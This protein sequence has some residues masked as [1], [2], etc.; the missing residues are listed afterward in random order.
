MRYRALTDSGDSTF[1]SGLTAFLVNTPDAVAQAVRTRLLLLKGEWFL[2][3]Q[4]GTPYATQVLGTGT[5]ATRDVVIQNRII[6]TQGVLSIT[7]YS[8]SVNAD[9][10][11]FSINATIETVYGSTTISQV[12]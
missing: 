12:L 7:S 8:S 9:T 5:Q 10:R 2:D 3:E 1:C 6:G 11:H 4:E